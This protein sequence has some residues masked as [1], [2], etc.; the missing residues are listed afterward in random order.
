L[1]VY[2]PWSSSCHWSLPSDSGIYFIISCHVT[3]RGI[4]SM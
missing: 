1:S 2:Y 3:T 4:G